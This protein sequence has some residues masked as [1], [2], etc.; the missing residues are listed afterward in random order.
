M[1]LPGGNSMT[2]GEY[3]AKRLGHAGGGKL[4]ERE[5]A[6]LYPGIKIGTML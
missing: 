2:L 1:V 6:R 3:A 4:A 5:L